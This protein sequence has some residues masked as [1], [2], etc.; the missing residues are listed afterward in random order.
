VQKVGVVFKTHLR[1]GELAVAL[2]KNLVVAVHQ[3]IADGGLFEQRIQRAEAEHLVQHLFHNL[4]LLGGG[5]G[6]AFVVEQAL[7]HT[8]DFGAYAVLGERRNAFQ[9]EHAD[10]LAMDFRFQLKIAI[11]GASGHGRH[12]AARG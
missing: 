4:R 12:I 9:V 6:D 7:H 11:G 1:F 2:D 10:Q 5:H 3:D 8:A